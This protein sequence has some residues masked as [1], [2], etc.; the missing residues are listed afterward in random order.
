MKRYQFYFGGV[1]L[2]GLLLLV[3]PQDAKAIT[4]TVQECANGVFPCV[5]ANI[6]DSGTQT[7]GVAFLANGAD[8]LNYNFANADVTFN[9]TVSGTTILGL[10][11]NIDGTGTATAQP[12]A[13]FFLDVFITESFLING[14]IQGLP[15]VITE[16]NVG[17][18]NAAAVAAGSFV[19]ATL[20]ANGTT[21]PIM[22]GA[23]NCAGGAF[24][25][26]GFAFGTIPAVLT[27]T[28]LAQFQ[29]NAS[30]AVQASD[31]PFGETETAP[32]PATFALFGSALVLAGLVR[33]HRTAAA[34]RIR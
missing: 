4:I 21:L 5:G 30:G 27:L 20:V 17:T 24:N 3:Q 28:G 2:A 32:E 18:C 13:G 14:L 22:G 11:A 33:K 16:Y 31:L 26:A 1:L 8:V 10:T 9:G 12:T 15:G 25:N 7:T 19:Q 6:I 29:F 34:A 23:G